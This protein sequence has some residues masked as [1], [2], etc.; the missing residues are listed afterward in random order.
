MKDSVFFDTNVLVYSTAANEVKGIVAQTLLARGGVMSIQVLNEFATV[1]HR[2]LR[3]SWAD[4][5]VA[6]TDFKKLCPNP[7]PLGLAMHEAAVELAARDGFAFYDALI[8]ASA[9]E[10]G[11]ATLFTEYMQ[12]GRVIAAT[13]TI[14]NPFA[15]P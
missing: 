12:D 2:K 10:A 11:C 5:R 4:I 3:W 14:R 1:A 7:R 13:L 8:V 6:L 15:V 9:L